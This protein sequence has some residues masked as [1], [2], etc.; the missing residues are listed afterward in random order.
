MDKIFGPSAKVS[1]Q[2]A[3]ASGRLIL[4]AEELQTESRFRK[5]RAPVLKIDQVRTVRELRGLAGI[6]LY[7]DLRSAASV[8]LES[9]QKQVDELRAFGR[10][11]AERAGCDF[12]PLPST[13]MASLASDAKIGYAIMATG[14]LAVLALA[15]AATGGEKNI[16]PAVAKSNSAPQ[17]GSPSAGQTA[18]ETPAE[19]PGSLPALPAEG[20]VAPDTAL[21]AAQA[22][23]DASRP[24]TSVEAP[25]LTGYG[26]DDLGSVKPAGTWVPYSDFKIRVA[27]TKFIASFE[28]RRMSHLY[29]KAT[30]RAGDGSTYLVLKVTAHNTSDELLIGQVTNGGSWKIAVVRPNGDAFEEGYDVDHPPYLGAREELFYDLR[31]GAKRSSVQIIEV[32]AAAAKERL[33]L[34]VEGSYVWLTN[35]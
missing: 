18:E 4:T 3:K 23:P 31:P 32:P 15:I 20:A 1:G 22:E 10:A 26:L 24:D 12:T 35:E 9:K 13:W 2:G 17:S 21:V 8:R 5:K 33:M 27:K 14:G 29:P 19:Q 16:R 7:V 28:N 34:R 6:V 11:V 30:Y 25:T